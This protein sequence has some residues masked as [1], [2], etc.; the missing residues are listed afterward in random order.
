MRHAIVALML[1]L[2]VATL[3]IA[4]AGDPPTLDDLPQCEDVGEGKL[5]DC[6]GLRRTVHD[7]LVCTCPPL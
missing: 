3:P 4:A 2:A 7:L 5:V 6:E 1:V